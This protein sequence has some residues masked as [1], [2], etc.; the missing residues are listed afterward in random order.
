MNLLIATTNAGKLRE[1]RPRFSTAFLSRFED[2]RR[3][4][5]TSP[6]AGRNGRHVRRERA[7]ESAA[8]RRRNRHGDDGRRFGI[9]S[10]RAERRAWNLLGAVSAR[11]RHVRPSGSPTSIDA[12]RESGSTRSLGAV[13]VRACRR[14]TGA[15]SCSKRRRPWKGCSR[16]HLP[17]RMVSATTRFSG[18]R[19]TARRS[20]KCRTTRKQPS[21]I[22]AKP[23]ARFANICYACAPD[24]YDPAP[25][26]PCVHC[27]SAL[28]PQIEP[29]HTGLITHQRR[30][31]PH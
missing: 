9:R 10:G 2:A 25:T 26:R 24:D 21:A 17:V 27:K 15:T 13:R 12:M 29:V 14:R 31:S 19:I 28:W 5:A 1:I 30:G 23:C 7:A 8:L 6:I 11:R 4:S 22:A 3:F 18:I 16:M 20:A